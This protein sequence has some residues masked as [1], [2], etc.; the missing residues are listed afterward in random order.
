MELDALLRN[1]EALGGDGSVEGEDDV[2]ELVV[3]PVSVLGDLWQLESHRLICGDSTSANVV[4]RLLG[5]V[6]P[7]LMVTDPPYVVDYDPPGTTRRA[8]RRPGA[9]TRG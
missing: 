7:L 5:D 9:P 3:A 6:K 4:A 1:P 2:P 8:R